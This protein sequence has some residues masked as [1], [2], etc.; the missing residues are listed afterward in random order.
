MSMIFHSAVRFCVIGVWLLGM[1]LA[2]AQP[3]TA[4]NICVSNEKSGD[5]SVID[6][7]NWK[8]LAT[9]P[10][11]KRPRGIV[12]AARRRSRA[13]LPADAPARALAERG[14]GSQG[15]VAA[16][17]IGRRSEKRRSPKRAPFCATVPRWLRELDD[18]LCRRAFLTLDDF[19]LDAL[20]FGE[21]L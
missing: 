1:V 2:R 8:V 16:R 10:V 11:G 6:G 20:A 15:R 21:R 17:A 3:A 5:I 13:G 12:A 9:I 14:A 4:Y 19:E 7:A 18:V